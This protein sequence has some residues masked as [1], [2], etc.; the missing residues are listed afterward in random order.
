MPLNHYASMPDMDAVLHRPNSEQSCAL[1]SHAKT[2]P[3]LTARSDMLVELRVQRYREVPKAFGGFE[4]AKGRARR[5][6]H[7]TLSQALLSNVNIDTS[8]VERDV[9]VLE[10]RAT[11]A[12]YVCVMISATSSFLWGYHTAVMSPAEA[13]ALPH[14]SME[15]WSIVVTA[16]VVGAILGSLMG[17]A[18]AESRGRKQTVLIT[19]AV[20]LIGSLGMMVAGEYVLIAA[21]ARVLL[22]I[23]AGLTMCVVPLYIGEIVPV[24]LRGAFNVLPQLMNCIGIL[25]AECLG[26]IELDACG[27]FGFAAAVAGLQLF[28]GLVFPLE[29]SPE[30]LISHINGQRDKVITVCERLYGYDAAEAAQHVQVMDSACQRKL[31][32]GEEASNGGLFS[33]TAFRT[34]TLSVVMLNITQQLSG[35]NAILQYSGT[36]F[37]PLFDNPNMPA[38]MVG[39]ANLVGSLCAM[40]LMQCARRKVLLA[41]SIGGMLI[42]TLMVTLCSGMLVV[43]AVVAFALCFQV[44]L[45]PLPGCLTSEMFDSTRRTSA[46]GLAVAMNNFSN[47]AVTFFFPMV[48]EALQG[49]TFAIFGTVLTVALFFVAFVVPETLNKHPED[50]HAD[51]SGHAASASCENDQ[52][53]IELSSRAAL[54]WSKAQVK[55]CMKAEDLVA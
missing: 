7:A 40:K 10:S 45:G 15:S 44:G 34:M 27:L 43:A 50:I 31:E 33:D 39:V 53:C 55:V 36:F 21:T 3:S 22:G 32:A 13:T 48:Y 30:F 24:Q 16:M 51:L 35:F 14:H 20:Y 25:T 41:I 26:L 1:I 8:E 28:A 46:Q 17:D 29:P 6:T 12:L 11:P 18:L 2:Q 23:S 5:R 42:A 19:S 4:S 9:E 38:V 54:E 49:L 47:C 37:K 52:T